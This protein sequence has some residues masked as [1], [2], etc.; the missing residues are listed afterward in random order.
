MRDLHVHGSRVFVGVVG[1][2]GLWGV[3][4]VRS[5][6]H[7]AGGSRGLVL[8]AALR[9]HGWVTWK[10]TCSLIMDTVR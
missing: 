6:D 8:A 9:L 1:V 10:R 3:G 5:L 7:Q 2:V 4:V